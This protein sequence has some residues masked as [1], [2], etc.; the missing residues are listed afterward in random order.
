MSSGFRGHRRLFVEWLL[1]TLLLTGFAATASMR[2]WLTSLNDLVFDAAISFAQRPVP[3]DI[4]LIGIDDPSIA[5]IGKWPWRR[6]LHAALIDTLA[7]SGARAIALDI[8]LTEAAPNPAADQVLSEAMRRCKRV[9]LPLFREYRPDGIW[10]EMAPIP[11]LAQAAAGLGHIEATVDQDGVMRGYHRFAGEPSAPHPHLGILLLE[12]AEQTHGLRQRS[13]IARADT[14]AQADG[15]RQ[16]QFRRIPFLAPAGSFTS[17]SYAD[18]LKGKLP[19]ATFTNKIVLVG[20]F[21][22][23]LGD[24]YSVPATRG[25]GPMPG[26][27]IIANILEGERSERGI[28]TLNPL[29]AA[30]LNTLLPLTAMLLLPRLR[31][32]IGILLVSAAVLAALAL[33][34]G[35]PQFFGTWWPPAGALAALLLA[36]P[37][38]SWRCLDAAQALIDE[39]L[40]RISVQAGHGA[41][42]PARRTLI[43]RMERIRTLRSRLD[44]AQDQREQALRFISHDMRA[45]LASLITLMESVAVKYSSDTTRPWL[46]VMRN[47]ADRALAMADDFLRLARAEAISERNFAACCLLAVV[48]EAIDEFWPQAHAR[49]VTISR[50]YAVHDSEALMLGEAG[51]LRR[52]FAN[53][54]SNAIRHSPSGS[55]IGV[56]LKADGNAWV[57]TVADQGSGISEDDLPKLFGRFYKTPEGPPASSEGTGLGLLIVRTVIERHGGSVGVASTVGV[58]TTFT[59]CLPGSQPGA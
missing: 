41:L 21:A 34:I 47:R 23:G 17:V 49:Q 50:D 9:V 29:L 44:A 3:Q 52:A 33:A 14:R 6:D 16:S 24:A 58:G 19:A 39:E 27:E 53:L 30:V 20:A 48:D 45:P 40:A 22:T 31:A 56:G 5:Q 13:A 2:G 7:H 8:L 43:D 4:V 12:V 38:W 35:M 55:R 46:A 25:R 59:V 15:W 1:I 28:T 37:L 32:R 26:V 51:L 57:V 54:L 42:P 10:H 11:Q 36:Y 18:V